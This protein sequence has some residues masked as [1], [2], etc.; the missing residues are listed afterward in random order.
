MAPLE[1]PLGKFPPQTID[2]VNGRTV[3]VPSH[4][5]SRHE[6][7]RFLLPGT[8]V[9]GYHPTNQDHLNRLLESRRLVAVERA[10]GQKISGP[11]RE[12][13]SRLDVRTRQS[14]EEVR[15][16]LFERDF[17]LLLKQEILI[18]LRRMR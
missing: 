9:R 1:G 4:F 14:G 5:I 6:R 7:H 11:F 2:A 12:L 15:K 10:L 3:Y 17:D 13:G 8:D 16:I 18:R